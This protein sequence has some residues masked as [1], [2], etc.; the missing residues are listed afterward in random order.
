MRRRLDFG[1]LNRITDNAG[2]ISSCV[3]VPSYKNSKGEYTNAN[4]IQG[5]EKFALAMQGKKYTAII[6]A[7]NTDHNEIVSIRNGYENIYTELSE[8]IPNI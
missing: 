3:G 8:T 2:S 6:L 5:I 7:N 1:G 4:F